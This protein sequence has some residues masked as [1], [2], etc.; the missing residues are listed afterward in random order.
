MLDFDAVQAAL[1]RLGANADA[2]ESHG[3]LCALLIGNAS[4]ADWLGHTLPDMPDPGDAL[5]AEQLEVLR[6]LYET[7]REQLNQEDLGL[8][9]LLPEEIEDFGGRLIALAGW[10]Q[11]FLYGIAAVGAAPEDALDD[12][13]RECLSDILEISKLAHDEEASDEAE[14]QYAEVAEHVR[15]S[16]LL[17]NESLNPLNSSDTLH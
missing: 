13:A 14:L 5:A 11:G 3:T 1:A 6:Q 12:E 8:E 7:T 16:A 10:C 15:M 2:A 17:L 4:L 9:L